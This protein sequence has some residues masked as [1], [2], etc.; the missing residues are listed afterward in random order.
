[1]TADGTPL[2]EVPT[3]RA[4]LDGL[5]REELAALVLDLC[6]VSVEAAEVLLLRADA[7]DEASGGGVARDYL[8]RLDAALA[9]VDFHYREPFYGGYDDESQTAAL[10]DLLDD[11]E[12]LI[13][14]GA[15]AGVRPVLRRLVER[16]AVVGRDPDAADVLDAPADRA[17][18][19]L[20]QACIGDVDPGGLARWVVA[21]RLEFGGFPQLT[22]DAF[23]DAF[24]ESGWEAYR[25]CVE[26]AAELGEPGD[27]LHDELARMLLE[28]AL[29]DGDVDAAVRLLAGG[30]GPYFGAILDLLDGAG[31]A[32]EARDWLDRAVAAGRVTS[33]GWGPASVDPSAPLPATWRPGGPRTRCWWHA[34]TSVTSRASGRSACFG[35]RPG[36]GSRSS[37]RGRSA[38]PPSGP[39]GGAA[40]NGWSASGW[41]TATSPGP[42]RRPR[43]SGLATPGK[44]WWRPPRRTARPGPGGSASWWRRDS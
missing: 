24:G 36:T 29:H 37:G 38:L 10:D 16:L 42:G 28:V 6:G 7:Q 30:A 5:T 39:R 41:P 15:G 2:A 27:A 1:M 40:V 26:A 25:A 19:L 20:G 33:A 13:G 18:A 9:A 14:G 43:D 44:S 3:V 32:E 31:R 21:R 22:S 23:A 11:L 34:G 12:S 17:V 4:Y 35:R 8:G